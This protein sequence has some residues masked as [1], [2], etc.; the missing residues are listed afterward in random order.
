MSDTLKR[1]DTVSFVRFGTDG[2]GGGGGYFIR[3]ARESKK[4]KI[5]KIEQ[6][7]RLGYR[8]KT[9][10]YTHTVVHTIIKCTAAPQLPRLRSTYK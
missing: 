1:V 7:R 3:R 8:V 2:G 10:K 5:G 9:N 6:N 4:K